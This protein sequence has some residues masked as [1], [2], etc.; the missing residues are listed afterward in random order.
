L[1]FLRNLQTMHVFLKARNQLLFYYFLEFWR[2]LALKNENFHSR[3]KILGSPAKGY[4]TFS[5]STL[6]VYLNGIF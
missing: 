3:V 6:L 4:C 1:R 5:G 2:A